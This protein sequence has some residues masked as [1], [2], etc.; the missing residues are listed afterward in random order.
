LAL[1]ATV[2][3]IFLQEIHQTPTG[4]VVVRLIGEV[5]G[6]LPIALALLRT[7]VSLFVPALDLPVW[8]GLP[9]LFLAFALAELSLGRTRTL[10]IAYA[11]TLAGTLSARAMIAL[12]PGGL[13]LPPEAGQALD[14]GPSAAVVGLFSYV[15]VIRRAPI[16]FALTGGLMVLQSVGNPNLAGREHLV[17]VGVAIVLATLNGRLRSGRTATARQLRS[18]VGDRDAEDSR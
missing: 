11:T 8:A 10:M 4:A 3:V 9:K 14:T 12:G 18:E 6:D 1:S 5:R 15:A 16:L 7:P 2:A 17:A 13:G